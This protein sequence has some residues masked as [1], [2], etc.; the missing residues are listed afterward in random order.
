MTT[1]PTYTDSLNAAKPAKEPLRI[2]STRPMQSG[3]YFL[4]NHGVTVKARSLPGLHHYVCLSCR[5]NNCEHTE[6][7]RANDPEYAEG[8]A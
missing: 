5:A 2:V 7:V 4:L 8:A 6:F 3:T 1:S